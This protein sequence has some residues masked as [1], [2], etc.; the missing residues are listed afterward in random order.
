MSETITVSEST[1]DVIVRD[2]RG[3]PVSGLTQDDF[4]V[5]EKGVQ[6]EITHF[7]EVTATQA[8]PTP[9]RILIVIDSNSLPPSERKQT[10]EALKKWVPLNIREGDRVMV[11][12][13][14]P[15]ASVK[16]PWT[17]DQKAVLESFKAISRERAGLLA[18][19][20]RRSDVQIQALLRDAQDV[21][22]PG[23]MTMTAAPISFG[24]LTMVAEGY[25]A[26]ARRHATAT[27][28]AI[29]GLLNG[30]TSTSAEK[31]VM[32]IVGSGLPTHP[33]MD[34]FSEL[35][36]VRLAA[37]AGT[38]PLLVDYQTATPMTDGRR[39]DVEKDIAA[40]ASIAKRKGIVVYGVNPL[41][42]SRGASMDRNIIY[43]TAD[44]QGD[45]VNN[46]GYAQLAAATSGLAFPG[47]HPQGALDDLT[48]D[49]R[50]YYE[51][52]Y[53]STGTP[54]KVQVKTRGGHRVRASLSAG[55]LSRE[56][57]VQESVVAHLL[58]EPTTNDLG[59]TL[60][61]EPPVMEKGKKKVRLRVLIPV[62]KLRLLAEAG[63]VKGSFNVYVASGNARGA[64]SAVNR[65]THQIEWNESDLEKRKTIG[66]SVNVFLHQDADEISVG[67][68]DETSMLTGFQR[69]KVSG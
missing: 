52:S 6:R 38:Y 62:D 46:S 48:K 35:D 41:R 37:A 57:L 60:Q 44:I 40:L 65:Q 1:I 15:A 34:M 13:L 56:Q 24:E 28:T 9:R 14:Q 30:F 23:S 25:A 39:Y 54:D 43:S 19:E 53:K 21:P 47:A 66:F 22:P 68:L 32:F 33:G 29:G 12:S 3:N 63:Q 20:R 5:F 31:K 7:A 55:G 18:A 8:A 4:L 17:T 27:I 11:V 59:I 10:L 49:L 42:F 36:Q 45:Q 26:A 67:V 50:S 16:V 2:G 64:A 69:T 61:N 58:A 51:I